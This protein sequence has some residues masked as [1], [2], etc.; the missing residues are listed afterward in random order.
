MGLDNVNWTAFLSNGQSVNEKDLYIPGQESPFKKLV[1]YT[2]ANNLTI[3]SITVSIKN[4]IYNSPSLSERGNFVSPLKPEKFWI[5]YRDRYFPFQKENYTFIG[6][7]WKIGN[8]RTIL[9]ISTNSERPI[10]WFEITDLNTS[11]EEL[12]DKYYK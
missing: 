6:L 7:S 8:S 5:C 4:T 2:I 9:W 10:S 3:N 12:I 11:L 1:K